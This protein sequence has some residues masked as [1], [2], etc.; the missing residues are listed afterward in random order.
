[1]IC[2]SEQIAVVVPAVPLNITPFNQENNDPLTLEF[3][4]IYLQLYLIELGHMPIPDL[5]KI[6]DEI[7]LNCLDL[8]HRKNS[9]LLNNIGFMDKG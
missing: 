4:S 7:I 6:T 1:M 3:P 2:G 8:D 5:I 9:V